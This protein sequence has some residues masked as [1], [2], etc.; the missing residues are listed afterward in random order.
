MLD[1]L[2]FKKIVQNIPLVSI[3]IC[4]VYDDKILLGKRNNEPLRGQ[5]FT[6]GGRILKNECWQ[7]CL[8]RVAKSELGI[9]ITNN[10]FK[11]MGIWDH[12]YPNSAV[13]DSIST[14]Y[15]NLP[16]Y[17]FLK[18]KPNLRADEQHDNLSWFDLE[19]VKENEDFHEYMQSYATWLIKKE[20]KND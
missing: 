9:N 10:E 1:P 16:H 20:I 7:D 13:G 15:V 3:D 19:V 14:H 4:L 8:R 17:C 2:T 18:E 6:P 11:L 5:W 12:F